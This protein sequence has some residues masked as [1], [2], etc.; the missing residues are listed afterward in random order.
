MKHI[1]LTTDLSDESKRAFAP[2][3]DLAKRLGARVTILHVMQVAL[4]VPYGYPY[5]PPPS[6]DELTAVRASAEQKLAEVV[7]TIPEGVDVDAKLIESSER[8]YAAVCAAADEIGADVIAMATHGH[9]GIRRLL[10]GST[11]ENVVRHAHVPV[12]LYPPPAE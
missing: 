3:A 2:V 4:A 7:A 1:L 9:A 12:W 8:V 5:V 10:L 6:V 11:A